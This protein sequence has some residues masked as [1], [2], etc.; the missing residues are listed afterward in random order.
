[1]LEEAITTRTAEAGYRVYPD[2]IDQRAEYPAIYY[3]VISRPSWQ[4][5][6]ER[7]SMVTARVQFD[8][9]GVTLKSAEA[10]AEEVLALWR[11]YRGEV[12]GVQICGSVLVSDSY[13]VDH[14]VDN[15]RRLS[16]IRFE[17]YID[18]DNS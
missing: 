6:T 15:R 10:A 4:G 9:Y 1:M 12:A 18:Y 8:V 7:F 13:T 14:E 11:G 5:L 3:D 2:V 17:V 16:H